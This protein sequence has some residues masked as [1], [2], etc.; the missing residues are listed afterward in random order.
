MR[1]KTGIERNSRRDFLRQLSFLSASVAGFLVLLSLLRQLIPKISPSGKKI[2]LG[3]MGSFPLNTYTYLPEHKIFIYRDHSGLKAISAV[4][5]HLGCTLEK[6]ETGFQCPCHGS[7]FNT[8]GNVISGAAS[9]DLPWY[10]LYRSADGQIM[11]DLAGTVDPDF[12]L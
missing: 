9:K 4:C 11:V 10:R 2:K 7:F 1:D 8:R 5:T 12:R 3:K 6:N